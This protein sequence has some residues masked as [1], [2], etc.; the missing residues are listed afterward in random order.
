MRII[1]LIFIISLI[2]CSPILY[3]AIK[4]GLSE[5]KLREFKHNDITIV[6]AEEH[7]DNMVTYYIGLS[8]SSYYEVGVL[9]D[10]HPEIL[11]IYEEMDENNSKNLEIV[12]N[13]LATNNNLLNMVKYDIFLAGLNL[14]GTEDTNELQKRYYSGI[15][16]DDLKVMYERGSLYDIALNDARSRAYAFDMALLQALLSARQSNNLGNYGGTPVYSPDECIGPVI[17]GE[18]KGTIV[19][20]GGYHKKCYGQMLNGQCTGPMF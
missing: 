6:V 1:S 7:N 3:E 10:T 4:P 17:M 2:S 9:A 14:L 20:K 19:P 16:G 11:K 5:Y 15:G 18:C 8:N 12:T 13:E